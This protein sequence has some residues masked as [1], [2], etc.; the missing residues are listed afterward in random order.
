MSLFT[1]LILSLAATSFAGE[2]NEAPGCVPAVE[3]RAYQK[4]FQLKSA[5]FG[6]WEL[7][8]EESDGKKV[9]SAIHTL[10]AGE[11]TEGS[12]PLIARVSEETD[13]DYLAQRARRI[14]KNGCS[15]DETVV[16]CVRTGEHTLRL[17]HAFFE[18]PAVNRVATLLHEAR[19]VD[20]YPHVTCEAGPLGGSEGGCDPDVKYRGSYAVELGYYARV[21]LNGKNFHPA[22]KAL[23]RSSAVALMEQNFVRNPAPPKERLAF[24]DLSDGHLQL[25]DGT[26]FKEH[27]AT[28][29]PDGKLIARNY[30]IA[31]LPRD[32]AQNSWLV[33]PYADAF[34]S[35]DLLESL[36]GTTF[37]N[38][39]K[40]P[41]AER[42][43][44]LDIL[45]RLDLQGRLYPDR[46]ELMLHPEMGEIEPTRVDLDAKGLGLIGFAAANL[47]W[48][49]DPFFGP[50][51]IP[52]VQLLGAGG[53]I[54]QV[55]GLRSFEEKP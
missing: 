53:K 3:A 55:K 4:Q 42:P 12:S 13:F 5:N 34:L 51:K 28:I 40:L 6:P 43:Q 22:F 7:C 45:N 27:R 18:I 33:D 15:G 48:R 17:Q 8:R 47:C 23:A 32:R 30:G 46:V 50:P 41:F 26:N 10:V 54:Y 9:L 19:H 24:L 21:A 44:I 14:Q 25:F 49:P 38:Y 35:P 37:R 2:I 36:L 11:F 39:N 31:V 29:V 20:G 1:L 16:A 52:P